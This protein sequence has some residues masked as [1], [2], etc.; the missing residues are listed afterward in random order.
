MSRLTLLVLL[1]L[2][3][4]LMARAAA[5]DAITSAQRAKHLEKMRQVAGSIRVLADPQRPESAVKLRQEPV[6]R[7]ADNTRQTYESSLW[8]WSAG[9]R[10]AAILAVEYYNPMDPKGPRWLYEIASLSTER[11]AAELDGN[12]RWTAEEPGLKLETLPDAPPPAEKEARR[13][14]QMKELRG[15]F[16]AYENAT[17]SGRIELRPLATPLLRYSDAEQELIDGAIFALANGTNPEVLLVLEAQRVE[18]KAAWR[19]ALVQMSG[20]PATVQLDDKEI[21]KKE[22]AD[23]PAV[24]ASYINGWI[25]TEKEE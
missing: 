1:L 20:E 10:P 9:G 16:T 6:L 11:I 12:F 17:F 21:W 14:A 18:E 23:P 25:A 24:Q 22:G 2:P 15:R 5:Q 8:I 7:Y 13:L 19:Y 3:M 4:S